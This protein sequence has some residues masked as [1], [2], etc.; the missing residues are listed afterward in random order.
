MQE[1]T[2]TEIKLYRTV[3][4]NN[5]KIISD[6]KQGLSANIPIF[7]KGITKIQVQQSKINEDIA[8]NTLPQ[9]RQQVLQNVQKSQFDAEANYEKIILQQWKPKKFETCLWILQKKVLSRSHNSLRHE[10]C[11]KQ[12]RKRTRSCSASKIQL[13]FQYETAQ[14]LCRNSRCLYKSVYE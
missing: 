7:N 8:R 6:N 14:F 11:P 13:S 4:L 3:S 10:Q 5:T 2:S 12:L 1:E 9:Q